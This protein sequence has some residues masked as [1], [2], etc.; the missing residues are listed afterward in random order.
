MGTRGAPSTAAR[1]SGY[2]VGALVN[3]ALLYLIHVRPGWQAVPFLTEDTVQVLTLVDAS[4]LVGLAAN[5]VYLA[6]D[7]TWVRALGDLVTTGVGLA[8][9]ARVWTVYPLEFA[10]S[11]LPW[12]LLARTVL[13]VA[14]AGSVVG[15]LVALVRLVRATG[16]GAGPGPDLTTDRSPTSPTDSRR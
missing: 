11:D 16:D 6:R 1:R 8:A 9:L 3:L 2:L 12:D 5:L 13:V 14:V 15:M 4:L 7:E 10:P